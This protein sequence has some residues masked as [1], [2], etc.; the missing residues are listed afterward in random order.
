MD[1][2]SQDSL[3]VTESLE[4]QKIQFFQEKLACIN[5]RSYSDMIQNFKIYYS[6]SRIILFPKS[7]KV[8]K[9]VLFGGKE[10]VK[11]ISLLID[12]NHFSENIFISKRK[13]GF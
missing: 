2:T 1:R 3:K 4:P 11:K 8:R 7:T 6:L 10:S 5:I 13:E 9:E 12:R